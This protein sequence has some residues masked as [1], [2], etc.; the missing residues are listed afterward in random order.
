MEGL[1]LSSD[2]DLSANL[3]AANG[4]HILLL[5][6]PLNCCVQNLVSRRRAGRHS[7]PAIERNTAEEHSRVED[8]CERL[9]QHT[10]VEHLD[11]DRALA[12]ARELLGLNGLLAAA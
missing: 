9:R 12:R 5:S 7:F 4:L 2:V 10:T 6:T 3:A 1:R 8:A 11:F